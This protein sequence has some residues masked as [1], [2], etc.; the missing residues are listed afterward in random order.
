MPKRGAISPVRPPVKG[1]TYRC[2]GS[3]QKGGGER[4]R[5]GEGVGGE[6]ERVCFR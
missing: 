1:S 2:V 6:G 3:G 5:V 4:V